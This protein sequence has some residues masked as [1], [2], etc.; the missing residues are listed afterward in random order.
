MTA[1]E[2]DV[3]KLPAMLTAL[4]LPSFQAHWQNF[5][6]RADKDGWSA[7]KFLA[8]LAECEL[9]ERET[10]RGVAGSPQPRT[11]HP[12]SPRRGQAA[13]RQDAGDL[14]LQG[15]AR[16]AQGG[17]RGP[18]GPAW[19]RRIEA[20]AAGDWIDSGTNLIAIGNSGA[21]KTHVL[22]AIG[23]TLIE[24]GFRVLYTR[25]T[26]LVQKLQAARR[27]LVLEAAPPVR[28]PGPSSTSS[29]S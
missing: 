5:A 15:A 29:T 28:Q 7:A 16:S 3:H 19:R 22:C 20:L 12:A 1:R 6:E 13:R 21:G 18:H 26:D 4:R 17:L 2:V 11:M 27:D 24:A 23:H 25:T 10:R 9:A 8:A 14:R